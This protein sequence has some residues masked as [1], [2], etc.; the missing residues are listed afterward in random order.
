MLD[1]LKNIELDDTWC[2]SERSLLLLDG[3]KA[4]AERNAVNLVNQDGDVVSFDLL[5]G[6]PPADQVLIIRANLFDDFP[7]VAVTLRQSSLGFRNDTEL[8]AELHNNIRRYVIAGSALCH[9]PA[10]R[11]AALRSNP[12]G[13]IVPGQDTDQRP[14]SRNGLRVVVDSVAYL[15]ESFVKPRHSARNPRLARL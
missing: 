11:E 13:S 4:V 15:L 7:Y 12:L 9:F 8:I 3:S 1:L 6:C 10:N 2:S 5:I 14:D